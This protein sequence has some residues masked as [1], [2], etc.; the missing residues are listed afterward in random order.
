MDPYVGE[1]RLF[2]FD[3]PTVGW[4]LC[5]GQILNI[6]AYSTLFALLGTQYGGNG[7]TTFGLPNLCGRAPMSQGTGPGLP[8]MTMGEAVGTETVTL[9]STEMPFHTHTINAYIQSDNRQQTPAQ[10][11]SLATS[12]R[13]SSF[14]GSV[15][16]DTLFAPLTIGVTGGT[17]GH[18]NRQP[19]LAL[20]YCIA[21]E[22]VFPQFS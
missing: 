20:N 14:L 18:E 2:G 13:S 9:L 16:P 22:G 17:Q 21:T 7:T 3:Y 1:I 4:M 11:S 19:Y 15:T 5:Q 10:G 8:P 12:T 6:S